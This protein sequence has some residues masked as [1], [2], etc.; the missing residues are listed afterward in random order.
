M[1][2]FWGVI[3]VGVEASGKSSLI[4]E[5]ADQLEWQPID[6]DAVMEGISGVRL[7]TSREMAGADARDMHRRH[8][9][10][11]L[12]KTRPVRPIVFA[13][14]LRPL[15]GWS[16]E[17]Q[18][19]IDRSID[20]HWL[21]LEVDRPVSEVVR[22]LQAEPAERDK[23]RTYRNLASRQALTTAVLSQRDELAALYSR[24][25]NRSSVSM[26]GT[27]E[28]TVPEAVATI[29]AWLGRWAFEGQQPST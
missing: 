22:V 1:G 18:Q 8:V 14:T 5:V 16:E 3:L 13:T 10:R 15:S 6:A 27:V 2:K 4:G 23:R 20:R 26:K 21:L 24:F 17:E 19:V 11:D 25:P 7:E 12:V 9:L 29:A 28:E